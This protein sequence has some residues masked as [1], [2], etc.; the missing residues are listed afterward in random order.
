MFLVTRARN[1]DVRFYI[2]CVICHQHM[3][4]LHSVFRC[5]MLPYSTTPSLLHF[6]SLGEF[7]ILCSSRL[8]YLP[9]SVLTP[10]YYLNLR[11]GHW[12]GGQCF[13][14]ALLLWLCWF[15]DEK[16]MWPMKTIDRKDFSYRSSS[17]ASVW[18]AVF[19]V[20]LRH[21]VPSQVSFSICLVLWHCWIRKSIRLW[22]I[23][24][25]GTGMVISP[26]WGANDL[27]MVQVMPRPPHHLLLYYKPRWFSLSVAGL[28]R[29]SW[30]RSRWTGV[31]AVAKKSSGIKKHG[32]FYGPHFFL[33]TKPTESKH[34]RKHKTLTPTSGLTSG[35]NSKRPLKPRW[36]V[37]QTAWAVC[38]TV[39]G[40]CAQ[41]Y[42]CT[43]ALLKVEHWFRFKFCVCTFV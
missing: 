23:E 1:L 34:W 5:W 38:I 6:C 31:V 24:R 15:G 41:W 19:H 22:K 7:Y 2:W 37:G 30:K 8:S 36:L 17:S 40:S 27:H 42:A 13:V 12:G 3:T 10:V 28:P 26:E 20:N 39:Y 16:G 29:L 18:M 9:A 25:W 11:P 32:R 33:I 35:S 4:T 43:W 21:P 14:F